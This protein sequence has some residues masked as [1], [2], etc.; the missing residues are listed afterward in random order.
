M[1]FNSIAII[2]T[3][4]K[5][6][7]FSTFGL[8]IKGVKSLNIGFYP[9]F[10]LGLNTTIIA[11]AVYAI[12]QFKSRIKQLNIVRFNTLLQ[13]AFMV[14][15]AFAFDKS[16]DVI[17]EE[18]KLPTSDVKVSSYLFGSVIPFVGLILNILAFR[19]IKKDE[20]LVRSA[21]RLR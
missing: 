16:F 11:M 8:H 5:E 6:F 20:E 10:L 13:M 18:L 4:D 15:T 21:D 14:V 19:G 17:A 2:I 1:F 9:T 3:I 7:I 12:T